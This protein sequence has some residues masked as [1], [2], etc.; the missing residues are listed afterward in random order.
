MLSDAFSV[1]S[2]PFYALTR[3]S[4]AAICFLSPCVYAACAVQGYPLEYAKKQKR[5]HWQYAEGEREHLQ[6]LSGLERVKLMICTTKDLLPD[7]DA[8]I[9]TQVCYWTLKQQSHQ[10]Y[11]FVSCQLSLKPSFPFH[12]RLQL[13]EYLGFADSP[14]GKIS[15]ESS[16]RRRKQNTL[17]GPFLENGRKGYLHGQLFLLEITG[18]VLSPV[19]MTMRL[20]GYVASQVAQNAWYRVER[21]AYPDATLTGVALL[22]SPV[23]KAE[24]QHTGVDFPS[25]TAAMCKLILQY[26]V[27]GSVVANALSV[28]DY[29]SYSVIMTMLDVWGGYFTTPSYMWEVIYRSPLLYWDY[30][31]TNKTAQ[32][33]PQRNSCLLRAAIDVAHEEIRRLRERIDTQETLIRETAAKRLASPP[34]EDADQD[35]GRRSKRGRRGRATAAAKNKVALDFGVE[36]TWES[37]LNTCLESTVGDHEYQFCFFGEIRQDDVRS[38][39]HF[40]HWGK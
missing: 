15:R 8:R 6:R 36:G 24:L 17:F 27:E 29:T 2:I 18:L 5:F 23:V 35:A 9:F 3:C 30:Y 25:S 10:Q 14:G 20:V 21:C 22:E 38:L 4:Y 34:S 32:L 13:G 12:P 39:G 16:P 19:T 1:F 40:S 31:V 33:P 26:D 11:D 28:I 7:E 37:V